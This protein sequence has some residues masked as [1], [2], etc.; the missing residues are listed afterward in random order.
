MATKR[1]YYEVL[2]IQQSASMTEIKK[3]YHRLAVELHPDSNREDPATAERFKEVAEAYEILSDE[4]KRE[5]Y[6]RLGPERFFAAQATGGGGG[7]GGHPFGDVFSEFFNEVFRESG[8]GTRRGQSLRVDVSISLE[9]AFS[10]CT[11][12]IEVTKN[13]RCALCQG[14]GAKP[15]AKP[16]LCRRC[17]GQ[18]QMLQN[19]GFV[20]VKTTCN[21]CGGSGQVITDHCPDCH[22]HGVMP[23]RVRIDVAIPAGID[24][25][26]RIRI[27]GEG[28]P[29]PDGG[30]PG[31]VI[32]FVQVRAHKLF[33]RDGNNL[34]VP[35]PI[36]F[37][38][39]ALGATI[40][41]PTLRGPE[42]LEIPR[43]TS[44]DSLFRLR[45]K[46][47]PDVRGGAPGDVIV[48][49][50]IEVPDSLTARQEELLREFAEI[51]KANVSPARKSFFETI[52]E[53]FASLSGGGKEQAQ[54]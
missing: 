20:R 14:T 50:N 42:K 5:R 41:V 40:E 33:R 54:T 32:C 52:G 1:C 34:I 39:A 21:A 7:G 47:M 19:L 38:Q 35:L 4:Q 15:G 16:K 6:D 10:G 8:G 28:D 48:Q 45:G 9:E 12:T 30:P 22:G 24:D 36:T 51:E 31:D 29:S 49:T 26:M 25:G 53:F 46:G 23:A 27:A 17:N 3:A 2:G 37:P 13:K 18:G 43:G 11:K 44:N